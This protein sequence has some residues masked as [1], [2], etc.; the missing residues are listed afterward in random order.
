[1]GATVR[2]V[3]A[4]AVG[5]VAGLAV[6][7][8]GSFPMGVLVGLCAMYAVFVA[9]GWAVLWPLDATS[10]RANARREEFRP[11]V[12]EVFVVAVCLGGLIVIGM[13]LVLKEGGA[14]AAA[15]ALGGVFTAWASLHLMYAAR[16][17][18]LYY[19]ELDG[20]GIDFNSDEPPAYRDFLYFSYNLG[21]TYQ[22]SDTSVSSPQIRSVVLR[23]CLLSY[24]FGVVVLA[25][26]INLV[27]GVATG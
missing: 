4:L 27:A 17:A 26:T 18:F 14:L 21:M 13:L 6:G 2:L 11:A 15:V 8:P 22:V 24:V 5:V 1:M 20:A 3:G 19:A 12:E 16:Y 9:L 7:I 10:T 25:S 23:H